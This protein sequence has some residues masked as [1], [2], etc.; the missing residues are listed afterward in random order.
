MSLLGTLAVVAGGLD[1]A[2]TV[3][4]GVAEISE[5][6]GSIRSRGAASSFGQGD[7]GQGGAF[8]AGQTRSAFATRP[9]G[10][11]ARSVFASSAPVGAASPVPIQARLLPMP[12]LPGRVLGPA[13]GFGAGVL[14]EILTQARSFTGAPV[15]RNK[16]IDAA[17]ACG[18]PLAA[19]TF[20]LSESDVCNVIASGRTKRSR[21]I[22]SRDIRNCNRVA[23]RI[24]TFRKNLKK[25]A[26]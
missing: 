4:T 5:T 15:S 13:V 16:I 20:G 21:G 14:S 3:A 9:S 25:A 6:V 22:S 17:R 12:R 1:L 24:T 26:K 23:R 8:T 10:Q 7:T 2:R 18:I 19:Q 11:D